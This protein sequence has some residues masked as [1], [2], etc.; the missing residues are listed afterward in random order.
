MRILIKVAIIL[1]LSSPAQATTYHINPEGTG[2]YPTIQA[3]VDAS[4]D[5]DV[6]DEAQLVDADRYL[7]V[8]DAPQGLHD[9][10]ANAAASG[11]GLCR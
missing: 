5:G 4:V 1:L 6:I 10:V 7:G 3:A 11:S 2:D 8:V 9:T